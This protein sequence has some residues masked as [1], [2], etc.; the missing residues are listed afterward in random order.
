MFLAID[1][2]E[3]DTIESV[4][5]RFVKYLISVPIGEVFVVASSR[6]LVYEATIFLAD[7]QSG[8]LRIR[9]HIVLLQQVLLQIPLVAI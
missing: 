6:E 2:I 3:K 5:N 7:P 4:L 1:A 8:S 9:I